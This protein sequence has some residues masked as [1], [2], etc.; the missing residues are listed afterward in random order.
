MAQL[1]LLV[2]GLLLSTESNAS[3]VA[4]RST[5]QGFLSKYVP[6][7]SDASKGSMSDYDKFITPNDN[8]VKYG[9][10][11]GPRTVMAVNDKPVLHPATQVQNSMAFTST[12][13]E[14]SISTK[15]F[16]S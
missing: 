1:A 6:P 2:A 10:A 9:N 13:R 3:D 16:H 7:G 4:D 14:P 15:D 8:R 5:L 11:L 12:R